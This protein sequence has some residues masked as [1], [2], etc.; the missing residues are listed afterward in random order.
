M[1][2]EWNFL[3]PLSGDAAL[4]LF[5]VALVVWGVF[6]VIWG[7]PTLLSINPVIWSLRLASLAILATIVLNPVRIERTEGRK[8]RPDL[9]CLVDGSR[10]MSLGNETSRWQDARRVLSETVAGLSAPDVELSLQPFRFGQRLAALPLAPEGSDSDQPGG[11]AAE[12]SPDDNDTRLADALRQ[13]TSRFGRQ[14][15]SGVVVLSDGRVRDPQAVESLAKEYARRNIPVHVYPLGGQARGGDI[16]LVS[17]VAPQRVRKYSQTEIQVFFRSFGYTG[18]R[19]EVRLEALEGNGLPATSYP[20]VPVTLTGGPQSVSLTWRSELAPRKL[21]VSIPLEDDELGNRNNQMEFEIGI[22]RTKIRVLYLEGSGGAPRV[23]RRGD[24]FIVEA[25]HSDLQEALVADED[26][27]CVSLI[28]LAGTSR[29]RRVATYD[30]FTSGRGFPTSRAELAAFDVIILSN[31]ARP[32]L[33]SEQLEWLESWIA[34]RGGGLCLM[35]GPR[36]FS[37][38]GWNDT[39]LAPMLPVDFAEERWED[40]AEVVA[41][42][43]GEARRHPVW[44]IVSAPQQNE[45]ILNG[46]PATR[47]LHRG[48]KAKEGTMLLAAPV[49]DGVA[50]PLVVAGEYGKGRTLTIGFP[51]AS[52]WAE[53]LMTRWGGGTTQYYSKFVR[54]VVYWLSETSAIGRRRLVA[55]VDKQFYRPGET[56]QLSATAF[57]ESARKVTG[58]R[59]WGMLE[60]QQLDSETLYAPVYWPAGLARDGGETSPLM[61]FGEEF[62]L[63][64]DPVD[65]RYHLPLTL[66]KL[67]KS[68]HQGLRLELTAYETSEGAGAG[69]R[70]TQVDSTS[71]DLQVLSDPFE[72]QNPLPNHEFLA[73]LAAISGG[74]VLR[75]PAEITRILEALPVTIGPPVVRKEPL[76]NRWSWWSLLVVLL[77]AEWFYRRKIGLA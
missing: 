25:G 32:S 62:E 38:G 43:V 33:T 15:P 5:V 14:P 57:D 41:A 16:A 72:Q 73:R 31:I 13:L 65:G 71:L 50:E 61:V 66:A 7:G 42:P 6:R 59:V 4:G 60:P 35:G 74:K 3:P 9:F 52:P 8:L 47:G 49:I 23:E 36:S 20:A 27:E 28:T 18:K 67:P 10:S 56:I 19:T 26:I 69:G 30:A 11:A 17:L 76:W 45:S 48:L 77:S 70:G 75:S 37:Q 68:D 55:S 12:S 58:Y 24:E 21:R 54:N 29:L 22:D 34:N 53:N 40:G 63:T 64:R 51:I 44:A 2:S 1:T 39:S 46:M